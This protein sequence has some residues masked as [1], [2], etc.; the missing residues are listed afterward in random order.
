VEAPYEQPVATT[1]AVELALAGGDQQG[2]IPDA[3]YAGDQRELKQPI[4][5]E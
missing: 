5:R 2:D 4:E 3:K 1:T